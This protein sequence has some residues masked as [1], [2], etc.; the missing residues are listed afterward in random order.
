M[1]EYKFEDL[2]NA[3]ENAETVG[4][5]PN[6]V[7]DIIHDNCAT[8]VLSFLKNLPTPFEQLVTP[9]AIEFVV[10]HL[11]DTDIPE[12]I[13]DYDTKSMLPFN[14]GQ[15]LDRVTVTRKLVEHYI[16]SH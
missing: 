16:G 3:Y 10:T 14:L 6:T 1:G 2:V 12:T 8:F 15:Y 11:S 13:Q 4:E 5:T 9:E 7:F